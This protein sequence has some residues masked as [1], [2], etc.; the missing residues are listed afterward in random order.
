MSRS[1]L[2]GGRFALIALAGIL[3]SGSAQAT[4]Q[5]RVAGLTGSAAA[6]NGTYVD[7]GSFDLDPTVG[8]INLVRSVTGYTIIGQAQL[9]ADPS[10][11]SI[12]VTNLSLNN[13]AG[14]AAGNQSGVNVFVEETNAFPSSASPLSGSLYGTADASSSTN[15]PARTGAASVNIYAGSPPINLFSTSFNFVGSSPNKGNGSASDYRTISTPTTLGVQ[16]TSTTPFGTQL[17]YS[18]PTAITFNAPAPAGLVMLATGLP[19]VGLGLRRRLKQ[20]VSA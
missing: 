12:N 20:A 18:T 11:Y 6:A 15:Q 5:I 16:F 17:N 1:M 10:R 4:F 2:G 9:T 7:N 8:S 13:T 19:V 14:S 3:Y